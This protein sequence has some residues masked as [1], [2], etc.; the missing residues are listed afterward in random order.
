MEG[1]IVGSQ[2]PGAGGHSLSW[3]FVT[4]TGPAYPAQGLT[5]NAGQ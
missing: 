5:L 4:L 2:P 1:V 3:I